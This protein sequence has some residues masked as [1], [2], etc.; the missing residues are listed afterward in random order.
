M[1][2]T[3]T[4]CCVLLR[5]M[6]TIFSTNTEES[7]VESPTNNIVLRSLFNTSC[8]NDDDCQ[9]VR[10]YCPPEIA[11]CQCS[12]FH[13]W[14]EVIRECALN[15]TDLEVWLKAAVTTPATSKAEDFVL[16][17]MHT[18]VII[19]MGI[20]A[21]CIVVCGLYGCCCRNEV[22]VVVKPSKE[23]LLIAKPA[24]RRSFR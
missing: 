6:Y 23:K 4:T 17:T 14:E 15:K 21:G 2:N 16:G 19:L 9:D 1:N 7:T 10:M 8:H 24:K 18:Q 20:G 5:L 22:N 11:K 13:Y 12:K 3:T